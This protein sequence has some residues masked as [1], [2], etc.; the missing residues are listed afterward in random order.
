MKVRPILFSGPMVRALLEGRKTQTRRII[1]PQPIIDV[2]GEMLWN[3]NRGPVEYLTRVGAKY[4]CKHGHIGDLLYVRETWV[5]NEPMRFRENKGYCRTTGQFADAVYQDAINLIG[6]ITYRADYDGAGLDDDVRWN[7]ALHLPRWLSRLTLR[8]T[9]VRVQRLQDISEEDA[10]A[11]GAV[12][13]IAGHVAFQGPIESYRRGFSIL[14]DGI[15]GAGEWDTNPWVWAISF[16]VIKQNVDTVL[17]E[18][19]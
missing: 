8:I 17:K 15:N 5:P 19:A 14:W 11:E 6:G 1:H 2:R 3:S 9:D 16:D 13:A 7:S 18:A 12:A 10:R 4:W